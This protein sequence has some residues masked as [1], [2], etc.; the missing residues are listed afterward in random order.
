MDG[1]CNSEMVKLESESELLDSGVLDE[2]ETHCPGMCTPPFKVGQVDAVERVDGREE[3]SVNTAIPK[4][5]DVGLDSLSYKYDKRPVFIEVDVETIRDNSDTMQ[6]MHQSHPLDSLAEENSMDLEME[7][8]D[9]Q[10][11]H[12]DEQQAGEEYVDA[13]AAASH[14]DPEEELLEIP[15]VQLESSVTVFAPNLTA[16]EDID[17]SCESNEIATTAAVPFAVARDAEE[18]VV[19]P[20]DN[21]ECVLE[22][23]VHD[24]ADKL[25]KTIEFHDGSETLTPSPEVPSRREGGV[26]AAG[27]PPLLAAGA[28]VPEPGIAP[29]PT[30]P[31]SL[32][33]RRSNMPKRKT[34]SRRAQL[35]E[36]P[37]LHEE[38]SLE[39][40]FHVTFILPIGPESQEF[41]AHIASGFAQADNEASPLPQEARESVL[42]PYADHKTAL[43]T[44]R[45][46]GPVEAIEYAR[47]RSQLPSGSGQHALPDIADE[48]SALS[49]ALVYVVRRPAA[50][51]S[52]EPQLGPI[53]AV[54]AS[55]TQSAREHQPCRFL[56]ALHDPECPEGGPR[57]A[58]SSTALGEEVLRELQS[59]RI[60]QMPCSDVVRRS[61]S[62]YRA[63][64]VH[65]VETLAAHFTQRTPKHGPEGPTFFEETTATPSSQES[66]PRASSAQGSSFV[67]IPARGSS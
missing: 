40:T 43:V 37:L 2:V 31:M 47:L 45:H 58:V 5:D 17:G 48:M 27:R 55:Y 38:R 23:P 7:A 28:A 44:L 67:S 46:V 29:T 32:P 11:E 60:G 35:T 64:M 18:S 14:E 51:D 4:P 36:L 33:L 6:H 49:N 12:L 15:E 54:E 39:T 65:V 13:R 41:A 25:L 53:C 52:Y 57:G 19:V 3:E 59:R 21:R 26:R 20:S 63:F 66:S 61:H 10:E 1:S 56:V 50:T 16:G 9:E 30:T 42:V 8:D 34:F 62:S 24:G 22:K